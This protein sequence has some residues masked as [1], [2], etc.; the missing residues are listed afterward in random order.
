MG[1]L[2]QFTKQVNAFTR[3]QISLTPIQ[4]AGREGREGTESR[5]EKGRE[6][7]ER[8]E[9]RR[10]GGREGRVGGREGEKGG[11]EGGRVAIATK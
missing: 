2:T 7:R 3:I 8:R 10:E 6:G 9:S 1:Y 5:R 4:E 11:R